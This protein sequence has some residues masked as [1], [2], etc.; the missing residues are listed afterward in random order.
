MN[1]LSRALRWLVLGETWRA[2]A[3]GVMAVL[4]LAGL[5][6][7]WAAKDAYPVPGDGAHFV[8]HG[9]ELAHGNVA[10]LSTYWSLGMI[11]VAAGSIKVGVDPSL[12]LQGLSLASGVAVVAVIMAIAQ[13]L[14]CQRR[15]ALL[16]G[17]LVATNPAMVQ[18]SIAGYSEMAFMFL[19]CAGVLSLLVARESGR[20]GGVVASLVLMGLAAY[21]RTLDA[22]VWCGVVVLYL[23]VD[24]FCVRPR[25]VRWLGLFMGGFLFLL[26]LVP[27]IANMHVRTGR[28]ALTSKTENLALG[29]QWSDS[30]AVY[31]VSG[32]AEPSAVYL[33]QHGA[34]VFLWKYRGVI[35][36]RL[37]R[38]S[39]EGVRI[40]AA[41]VFSGPFRVGPGWFVV[42]FLMGGLVVFWRE[43]G[44]SLL[45]PGLLITGPALMISL[46]FVHDRLLMPM[47]PWILL[48]LAR[49]GDELYSIAASR[50]IRVL[51][52]MVAIA[53][54]AQSGL[55]AMHSREREW[56]FWRYPNMKLVG[57]ELRRYGDDGDVLMVNGPHVP[58]HFYQQHPLRLV[59]L[60]YGSLEQTEAYAAE[61]GVTLIVVSDQFRTHWPIAGVFDGQP[62]PGNWS[63]VVDLVC[64]APV[65]GIPAETYRIY[66]RT[67][68]ARSAP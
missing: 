60:P 3:M 29:D 30:K 46:C 2:R 36:G 47:L 67:D 54:L 17:L 68:S 33:R 58:I 23:L 4:F 32:E 18:Y 25:C 65:E 57:A 41:Q 34:L 61:C 39:A 19:V 10:G 51:I 20:A 12:A 59:E 64:P 43:R 48:L 63:K 5:I 52:L 6:R 24:R 45:L 7:V 55:S 44:S 8:Q 9:V 14:F 62:V 1:G 31:R 40:F 56:Y 27:M 42:M 37:V 15:V 38:N 13:V 53:F 26:L 35:A 22:V 66:R 28:W 50:R 49:F 21:F 11:L 16:S